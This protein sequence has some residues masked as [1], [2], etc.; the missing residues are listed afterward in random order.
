MDFPQIDHLQV[1]VGL[2]CMNDVAWDFMARWENNKGEAQCYVGL[3][4]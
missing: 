1:P 3:P 2:G 4:L